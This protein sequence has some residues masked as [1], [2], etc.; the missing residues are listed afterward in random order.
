[1]LL[2]RPF[3]RSDH[4][5]ACMLIWQPNGFLQKRPSMQE[6]ALWAQSTQPHGDNLLTRS[7]ATA[8]LAT[9]D[10]CELMILKDCH[11]E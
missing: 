9:V 2:L 1:M 10:D 3:K 7:L 5:H 6:A 4:I 11:L 8:L